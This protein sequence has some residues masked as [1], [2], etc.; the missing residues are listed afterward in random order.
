MYER[1]KA[2]VEG[3]LVSLDRLGATANVKALRKVRAVLNSR[4]TGIMDA[5][6]KQGLQT[7][8][9]RHTFLRESRIRG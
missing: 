5:H 8:S 4:E 3:D 6:A 9:G 7:E 1:M 2:L